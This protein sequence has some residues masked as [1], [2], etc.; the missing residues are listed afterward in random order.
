MIK[1]SWLAV[2]IWQSGPEHKFVCI[3]FAACASLI[4]RCQVL[5][6]TLVLPLR[7]EKGPGNHMRGKRMLLKKR[8]IKGRLT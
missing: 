8:G 3:A 5:L 6:P 1:H 4:A 7:L 2:I